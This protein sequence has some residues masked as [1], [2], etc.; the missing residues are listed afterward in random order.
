[1]YL[2]A[3]NCQFNN[4]C[5]KPHTYIWH[6]CT[7]AVKLL[8]YSFPTQSLINERELACVMMEGACPEPHHGHKKKLVRLLLQWVQSMTPSPRAVANRKYQTCDIYD[9]TS[10]S[11]P[12]RRFFSLLQ[13]WHKG[14]KHQD[15]SVSQ[16]PSKWKTLSA[17]SVLDWYCKIISFILSIFDGHFTPVTSCFYG[18]QRGWIPTLSADW[19]LKSFLPKT[20][21]SQITNNSWS[22]TYF[23]FV[24][25]V[26]LSEQT[27]KRAS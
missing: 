23:L 24:F 12:R 3:I 15:K 13:V 26:S 6:F 8:Q 20:L 27:S 22:D 17:Q 9:S 2:L 19:I 14:V 5:L 25:T 4:G 21:C 10:E 1:M 16:F 18:K 7:C 11:E